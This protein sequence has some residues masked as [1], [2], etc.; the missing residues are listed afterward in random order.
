MMQTRYLLPTRKENYEFMAGENWPGLAGAGRG[1]P[2]LAGAGLADVGRDDE[3]LRPAPA[4]NWV[5]VAE[6]ALHA[7]WHVRPGGFAGA[8][9]WMGAACASCCLAHHDRGRRRRSRLTLPTLRT[10][11]EGV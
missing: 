1:W 2:M 11:G 10:T 7:G 9:H 5:E 4:R 6:C 8:P 3:G